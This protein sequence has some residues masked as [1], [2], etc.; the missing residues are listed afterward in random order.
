MIS[1]KFSFI[2]LPISKISSFK[3]GIF[4][5]KIPSRVQ[6]LSQSWIF[7]GKR[8]FRISIFRPSAEK[9]SRAL[10]VPFRV[11]LMP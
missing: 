4:E 7:A 8:I 6:V 3:Y 10:D 5:K 9:F 1:I 11:S 2:N